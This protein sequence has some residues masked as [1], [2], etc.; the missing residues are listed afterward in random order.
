MF[1]IFAAQFNIFTIK[2]FAPKGPYSVQHLIVFDR[3]SFFNLLYAQLSF[4]YAFQF[5]RIE[6]CHRQ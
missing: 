2:Y 1:T 5:I 6:S 3:K 4:E